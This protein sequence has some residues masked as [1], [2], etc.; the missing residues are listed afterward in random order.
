MKRLFWLLFLFMFVSCSTVSIRDAKV[1]EAE[2]AVNEANS[3][4]AA[5]GLLQYAAVLKTRGLLSACE[6]IAELGLVL[7]YRTSW[8]A[9]VQ[10]YLGGLSDDMPGEPPDVPSAKRLCGTS[11][12][13]MVLE[14]P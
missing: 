9:A 8:H 7:M 12:V 5:K 2:V 10:R 11:T 13:A 14:V 3:K 4:Q 6:D 1:Y